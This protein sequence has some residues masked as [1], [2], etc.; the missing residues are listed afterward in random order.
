M[1]LSPDAYQEW[2]KNNPEGVK[3][4]LENSRAAYHNN[5]EQGIKKTTPNT[6]ER[7][8]YMRD[9]RANN[10]DKIAKHSSTRRPEQRKFALKVNYGLT[11][12]NYDDIADS[13]GGVCAICK[14]LP[15]SYYAEGD[16]RKDRDPKRT[17][18][19]DHNHE[20]RKIRGLL[21]NNCNRALGLLKHDEQILR[22]LVD[23]LQHA[24]SGFVVPP[25]DRVKARVGPAAQIQHKIFHC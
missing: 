7:Q 23:Y 15:E 6:P 19:V 3:K 24:D 13:Q 2:R 9:W 11:L 4:V 1:G 16:K 18:C 20:N 22:N 17:L 5:F 14:Q 10:K 21:C 12:C 25:A 8:K